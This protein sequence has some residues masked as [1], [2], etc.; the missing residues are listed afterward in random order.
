M[1]WFVLPSDCNGDSLLFCADEEF[2]K[3]VGWLVS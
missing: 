3:I 2:L 1:D